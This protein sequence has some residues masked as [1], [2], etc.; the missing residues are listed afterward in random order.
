MAQI[1]AAAEALSMHD[2]E[3]REGG[4]SCML[5]IPELMDRKM[6]LLKKES[7]ALERH[8]VEQDASLSHIRSNA[9]ECYG[10]MYTTITAPMR[11]AC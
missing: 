6:D 2:A 9:P 4:K 8:I 3:D 5:W 7:P 1:N 10:N 11:R